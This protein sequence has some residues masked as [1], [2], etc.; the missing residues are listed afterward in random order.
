MRLSLH[1]KLNPIFTAL[2]VL[3]FSQVHI[4]AGICL[5][6]DQIRLVYSEKEEGPL[7]LAVEALKKDIENVLNAKNE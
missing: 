7:L 1:N 6:Q 4:H 5:E 2:L 3:L